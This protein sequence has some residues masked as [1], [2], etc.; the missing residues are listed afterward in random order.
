MRILVVWIFLLQLPLLAN[1]SVVLISIDG[2][3]N[4]Y[5]T[6]YKPKHM[7]AL[8]EGGVRAEALTPVYPSKTFP[9]HM[10]LVTGKHPAEHGIIH[11][12]FY[13]PISS[14]YYNIG[15]VKENPAWLHALPIWTVAE[16]QGQKSAIYFWPESE[17]ELSGTLPS[18]FVP[19]NGKISNRTRINKVISWLKLPENKRPSFIAT[20]FS[21]LDSA[22]HVYGPDSK[23]VAREIAWLDKLIGKLVTA[24]KEEVNYPVDIVLVSDHGMTPISEQS[25]IQWKSILSESDTV[26]V[27]NGQTQLLIYANTDTAINETRS[28]LLQ[29]RANKAYKIYKKGNFPQH[30]HFKSKLSV[31]PDLIV[32]AI[33]PYTFADENSYKGK[34]THGYDATL[35]SDL[36]AIFIANGPSFKQGITLGK[37]QNVDIFALLIKIMHLQEPVGMTSDIAPFHKALKD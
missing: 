13:N 20:Y 17:S 1:A 30:W 34:G 18:M 33:P 31:I 21:S 23:Q 5:L 24:I 16:Q 15:A 9:N 32:E 29:Y 7:L 6:K 27:V 37:I 11:N 8:A 22:G 3:A 2:F 35:N 28:Q 36:N 25:K 4:D 14:E 19:Y 12:S 26:K 10:S